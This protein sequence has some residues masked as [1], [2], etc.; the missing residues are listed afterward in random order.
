MVENDTLDQTLQA[1]RRLMIDLGRHVDL[2]A[3]GRDVA[4][5]GRAWVRA[6]ELERVLREALP[7]DVTAE[8]R[9]A[10]EAATPVPRTRKGR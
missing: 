8:A 2:A 5:L 4:E 7:A 3:D 10:V 6:A 1:A 9:A